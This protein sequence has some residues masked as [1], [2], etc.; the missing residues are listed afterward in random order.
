MLPW[1]GAMPADVG[2][3]TVR[4][5]ISPTPCTP[6]TYGVAGFP[7]Y[8]VP[9][10]HSRSSGV[11]GA[12]RTSTSTCP[13]AGSGG[14]RSAT[15]GGLPGSTTCSAFTVGPSGGDVRVGQGEA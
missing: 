3:Q 15:T 2:N 9:V 5:S 10:A 6:G 14:S 12:A 8:E 4:P 1:P 11:I 13:S 7:K